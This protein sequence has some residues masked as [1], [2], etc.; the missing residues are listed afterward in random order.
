[1]CTITKY[2]NLEQA[3]AKFVVWYSF[4]KISKYPDNEK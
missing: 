1:M 2:D 3:M 4:V